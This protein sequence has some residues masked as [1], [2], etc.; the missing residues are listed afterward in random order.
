MSVLRRSFLYV[1]K[2]ITKYYKKSLQTTV[3]NV[4]YVSYQKKRS[5]QDDVCT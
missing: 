1:Q 4:K 2:N 5:T 3:K